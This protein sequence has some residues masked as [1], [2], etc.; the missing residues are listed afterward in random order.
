MG[1]D[2][3]VEGAGEVEAEGLMAGAGGVFTELG[4]QEHFLLGR[5][6]GGRGRADRSYMTYRTYRTNFFGAGGGG[7]GGS[8]RFPGKETSGLEGGDGFREGG[9]NF[10]HILR[11]VGD[12]EE[13]GAAF[14][15]V[16][17]AQTEMIVEEA[18]VF[19]TGVGVEHPH[20]AEAGGFKWDAGFFEKDVEAIHKVFGFGFDCGLEGGSGFLQLEQD[21]VGGGEGERVADEGAGE[22]GDADFGHGVVAVLPGT[23][24]ESVHVFPLAAN[25]AD[26]HAA[27]D[28]FAVGDEVGLDAEVDLGTAGAGAEA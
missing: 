11:G 2:G 18:E 10:L 24:I 19:D 13:G 4:G 12:A 14:P 25:D 1:E 8:F 26:G 6:G 27:A 17:P 21:G 15:E 7:A 23:A 5:S 28:D 22:E 16:D 3:G 9:E 20:A